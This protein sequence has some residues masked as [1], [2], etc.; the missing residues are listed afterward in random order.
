MNLEGKDALTV[1]KPSFCTQANRSA[2][3]KM[4]KLGSIGTSAGEQMANRQVMRLQDFCNGVFI[5]GGVSP[6]NNN[7]PVY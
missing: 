1:L 3:V 6:V 4:K 2:K 7:R 5:E